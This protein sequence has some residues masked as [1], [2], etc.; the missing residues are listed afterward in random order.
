MEMSPI[1]HHQSG[2]RRDPR[3]GDQVMNSE[4]DQDEASTDLY[5]VLGYRKPIFP[6]ISTQQWLDK[7]M[8]IERI[9]A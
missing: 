7:R 9:F 1:S 3:R 6:S 4:D 2:L 5:E 8:M